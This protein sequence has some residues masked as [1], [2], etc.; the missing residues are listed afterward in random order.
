MSLYIPPT[1]YL[2]LPGKPEKSSDL[3]C[4]HL[5]TRLRE[6]ERERT[7]EEITQPLGSRGLVQW[8]TWNWW[9]RVKGSRQGIGKGK[10]Q[11]WSGSFRSRE[12]KKKESSWSK[13]HKRGRER[14]LEWKQI[15]FS[16]GGR[17]REWQGLLNVL[18]PS[19][20][21]RRSNEELWELSHSL[22]SWLVNH[23]FLFLSTSFLCQN[24]FD[25]LL[26][27]CSFCSFRLPLSLSILSY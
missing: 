11:V 10:E 17:S 15:K 6:Q 16:S 3:L 20:K 7:E 4:D 13:S 12:W 19:S 27:H 9:K 14:R 1:L 21:R 26:T 5:F 22:L 18:S 8:H 23:V 25:C 24:S 2:P